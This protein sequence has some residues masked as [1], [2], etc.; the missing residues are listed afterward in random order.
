[1]STTPH[2]GRTAQDIMTARPVCVEPGMTVRDVARIFDEHGISGAP[3]VDGKGR[4]AGVV[5]RTDLV[6]RY[7][8]GDIEGDPGMLI[9]LFRKQ[10][11]AHPGPSPDRLIAVEDFMTSNPITASPSTP[12]GDLARKMVDARVHRVIVVDAGR[13]PVGI[14]T[15]LDLVKALASM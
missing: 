3:V 6:R 7:S 4:L 5:S 2:A 8:D 14:V 12:V 1:M 13:I 9:E 15:S 11:E 10:D